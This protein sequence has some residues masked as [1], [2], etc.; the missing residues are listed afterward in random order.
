MRAARVGCRQ[1]ARAADLRGMR[2]FTIVEILIVML[3][4]GLLMA[5]AIP[6]AQASLDRARV[7]SAAAD[8]RSTFGYARTLAIAGQSAVAVEVDSSAGTL[9]LRRDAMLRH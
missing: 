6:R 8:V 1:A 5:I 2:G 7:H 9:T 4:T 3:V